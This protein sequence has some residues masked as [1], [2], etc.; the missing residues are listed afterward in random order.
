MNFNV[1]VLE[2]VTLPKKSKKKLPE[3]FNED[4]LKSFKNQTTEII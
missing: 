4:K 3:I 1:L 2:P